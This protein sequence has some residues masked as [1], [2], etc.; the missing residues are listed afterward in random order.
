M[1]D[2]QTKGLPD[3]QEQPTVRVEDAARILGISRNSAYEGVRV[4]EIPSIRVGRR[5]MVPTASLLKMVGQ[6]AVATGA[7]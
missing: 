5:V 2:R 7:A 3:P 4:G 1:T 6:A